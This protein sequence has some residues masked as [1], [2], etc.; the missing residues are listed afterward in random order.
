[1]PVQR[2]SLPFPAVTVHDEAGQSTL[3][4][5]APIASQPICKLLYLFY[6]RDIHNT[7]CIV[8]KAVEVGC[9]KPR[10]EFGVFGRVREKD[11]CVRSRSRQS[12]P[13]EPFCHISTS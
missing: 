5:I 11:E 1:M 13:N 7:F 9:K 2:L 4:L 10:L 8:V 3:P 6:P 12:A